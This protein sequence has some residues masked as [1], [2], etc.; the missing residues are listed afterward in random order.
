MAKRVG[1]IGVGG[2]MGSALLRAIAESPDLTLA[3]ALD[4]PGSTVVGQDAGTLIG[5]APSGVFVGHDLD[6]AL[7][8]I[9]V[10][11]DFSR[12]DSA[13]DHAEAC[14]RARVPLLVGTTGL[15]D[16]TLGRIDRAAASVPVL[17]AANTSLAL[18]VL[19][20]LVRQ[21][22]AA[23]PAEFDIEIFEAHHRHKVDAPSGTALA[24]ADAAAA[25]RGNGPARHSVD[26]AGTRQSGVI[27]FSVVRGGDV[28]GEHEVRFLGTGEQLRLGHVATD[29]ALFARGALA[30]AR[31][32]SVQPPGRYRMSDFLFNKQ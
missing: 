8:G 5:G 25:G 4:R 14:V 13:G 1:I 31:W 32:L 17:V 2:R 10:A 7:A 22:A 11:I 28:I 15:D 9:D 26:R 19:L 24:L 6:R 3:S 18:N 23:L 21:A 27:G 30:A 29:R 20:E 12:A 16:A